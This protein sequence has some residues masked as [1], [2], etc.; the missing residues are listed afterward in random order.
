MALHQLSSVTVGVPGVDTAVDYYQ[1]FGLAH[2]EGGWLATRDAGRQMRVV[3]ASTRRLVALA[4]GA[5]DQ[6]DIARIGRQ[7]R[8]IGVPAR[9]GDA[10]VV[11]SDPVTDVE[12]TVRVQS[13]LVLPE[14]PATPYNGPGRCERG[15]SRAQGILRE[16]PVR[17][18]RL[19]HVVIGSADQQVLQVSAVFV[20][21]M[22]G[23][24]GE[25]LVQEVAV[26]A[27]ELDD[28]VSR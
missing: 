20:R 1:D 13:R 24:G 14:V 6:D 18:R 5:D 21:P 9:V 22:V 27:V 26:R 15:T 16:G 23:Q 17:P 8:A 4:I 28:L 25:E 7:L 11:A 10:F 2:E 3:H 19:G 12:V